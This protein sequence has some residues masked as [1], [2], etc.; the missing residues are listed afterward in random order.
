M[1][2]I[3]GIGANVCDTLFTVPNY[4]KEDTKMRADSMKL[5]GGGPCATGLVAASKLGGECAYIGNLTDDNAGKFLAEDMEKYNVST[6]FV[7][8][9][10]GCTSFSSCIWLS[11]DS[12][13]R[14]CVFY[15]GDIPALVLNDKQKKAI[16]DAKIL[17]IDGNEM[18]AAEEA[19]KIANENGTKVLY[20]A[21]GLYVGVERLLSLTDILIPSEEFALGHTGAKT[22]EDA[23]KILFEKYSPE[24]VVITQGKKGGIIFDGKE[25]KEYPAFAVEAVDS[26]G[27]GDV[28]HGAFAFAMNMGYNYYDA[29]V[30]SSAVSALKCTKVGAR[31]GVPTLAEVKDFLKERGVNV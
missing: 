9:I 3:V 26:N 16:A 7:N 13:A 21:G 4:P 23:A 20:D 22:A 15:K 1:S 29:C 11:K 2:K 17:M 28:F 31:E 25:V 8:V 19:C 10:G 24:I 6:D 14:T 5:S 18:D 30:F 27:S 12:A